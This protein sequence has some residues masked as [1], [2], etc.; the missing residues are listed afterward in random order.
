MYPTGRVPDLRGYVPR[1]W[2]HGSEVD[3]EPNRVI[4]S[5]QGDA[6]RN[7]TGRMGFESIRTD[8]GYVQEGALYTEQLS[9]R[10]PDH[11]KKNP[12]GP[13]LFD[14]SR[15]VPTATENRVKNVA[16][17]FIVKTDQ[18]EADNSEELPTAIVV[19]PLTTIL[20]QG[21]TQQCTASVLPDS[22]ASSYP[23]T[24]SVSDA[25]LGSVNA[26]GLYTAVAGKSGTQTVIASI[27]SGLTA[28]ITVT[29]HIFLT[30]IVIGVMPELSENDDSY[31]PAITFTPTNYSEPIEYS[32]SESTVAAFS[33]GIVYP[34][35]Q[36]NAVITIK[37][38][39]SNV[40][41]S[42]TVKVIEAVTVEEYLRI[43][44]N[45][46][47]IAEAGE[48]AQEEAQEHLGLGKLAKKDSLDAEDVGAAPMARESLPEDFD[49]DK[50]TDPGDYFQ[51]V[52][53]YATSEN[54]YPEETAGAVR[55][56]ATGVSEGACRQFYWP[57]NSTKEYRRCGYG[58]P[59][60]FS[61]W[62]EK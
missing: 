36:G 60:V 16:T 13:V 3:S 7:I 9:T 20:E 21:K 45:L 25:S 46:A 30:S 12:A 58:D 19:T 34:A 39:Y 1:G 40:T 23:V 47:E 50:L 41:G 17:M 24:W 18:S 55:V 37:G 28:T 10:G 8:H 5:I 31:T 62:D 2:A 27:S 42:Q 4:G 49:L 56:V 43:G 6:I 22:L 32:S 29:Q 33:N 35:G 59:I 54:H 61:E 57:Y 26:N 51:S 52:S 48:D 53:S 38:S 14:A 44:N 15:I 11:D